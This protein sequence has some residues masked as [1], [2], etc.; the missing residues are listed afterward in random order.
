MKQIT[1]LFKTVL[2]AAVLVSLAACSG[3]TFTDPGKEA[4]NIGGG[5]S[6][7]YG[8][9]GDGDYEDEEQDGGSVSKP[10][11]LS[12]SASYSTTMNKLDEIIA[13]C[14]SHSGYSYSLQAAQTIKSSLPLA[15]SSWSTSGPPIISS[16]NS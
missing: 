15:Q 2:L 6:G 9:Y 16:I 8:D 1:V 11:R 3:G 13:Y 10:S 7:D 4:A 12:S 5:G 14:N